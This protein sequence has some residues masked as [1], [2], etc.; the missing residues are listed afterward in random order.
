[1]KRLE[2]FFALERAALERVVSV[3]ERIG[4]IREAILE[5]SRMTFRDVVRGAK[6]K[7]DVV[8]SFLALLE[9]VKQRLVSVVQGDSFS[10]IEIKHVE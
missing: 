4:Q 1:M 7:V 5:R 10:D 2:P 3:Q 6:S 9:L 8:V